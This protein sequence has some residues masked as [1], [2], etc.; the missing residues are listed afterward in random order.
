MFMPSYPYFVGEKKKEKEKEKSWWQEK[1][2]FAITGN[3][4]TIKPSS[5]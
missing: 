5:T 1:A 3:E 2:D 4:I